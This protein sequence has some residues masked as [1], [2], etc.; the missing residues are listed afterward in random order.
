MTLR[1]IILH[2]TGGA[3]NPN[4]LDL[5]HYHYVIDGQGAVHAGRFK[6]EANIR[7]R[8]GQ[9]A[10]HTLRCNTGSIG[11]AVAAMGGATDAPFAWGPFPMRQV[12][13]DALSRLC[14]DLARHHKIAVTRATILSH[15][16][17]Q[18][19]LKIT[20]RGKWDIRVLPGMKALGDPVAVGD[21]LRA[22]ISEILERG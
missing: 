15:A 12:Q 2:W 5:A 20:Q 10:A 17:V 11:V 7:P 19:T 22:R 18:P 13:I 14:A 16:E 21:M 8:P 6:P 4:S 9:Y 3:Y 1:R